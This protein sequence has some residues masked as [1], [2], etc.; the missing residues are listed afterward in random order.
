M[1]NKPE[2]LTIRPDDTLAES[3]R[4]DF[5]SESCIGALLASVT[6]ISESIGVTVSCEITDIDSN[7][8]VD[9]VKLTKALGQL[10]TSAGAVLMGGKVNPISL[11]ASQ[12][13]LRTLPEKDQK[14]VQ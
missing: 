7:H 2:I 14:N 6:E 9:K 13:P 3:L 11:L 10:A 4:K 1:G 8:E 5:T 12:N